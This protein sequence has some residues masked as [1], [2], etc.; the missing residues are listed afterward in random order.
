[1]PLVGHGLR[2][3]ALPRR[4]TRP[5]LKRDPLGSAVSAIEVKGSLLLAFLLLGGRSSEPR[6]QRCLH[7]APSAAAGIGRREFKIKRYLD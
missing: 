5:Q 4:A 7:Y 1:M 3:T 6:Q 2:Q